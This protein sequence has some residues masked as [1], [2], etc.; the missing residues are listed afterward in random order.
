[1]HYQEIKHS[2][3]VKAV[4]YEPSTRQMRILFARG[5]EYEYDNVPS[6]IHIG[7]LVAP[8]AGKYINEFI[9]GKYEFR[10]L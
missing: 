10:K 2:T 7:L 6:A 8:S 9:K 3:Q 5:V 4:G 1:M